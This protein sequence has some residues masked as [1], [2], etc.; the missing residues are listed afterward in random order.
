M[1]GIFVLA[2]FM[3]SAIQTQKL[4]TE[5]EKYF[6]FWLGKW[7]VSWDE[8]NGVTG[9]GTNHI[10]R[11]LDG[12]VI[13]ENFEILEGQSKGFK[14]TS[15]SVYN[16]NQ[17]KWKQAWADSQGGY[18]DFTGSVDGEKRMFQSAVINKPDGKRFTQRMVF[19]NIQTN[20]L[21]WDW[22]SSFDGGE[23]WELKW[24]I[25]YKREE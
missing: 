19:Y 23:T 25:N 7:K 18:Y 14:G 4:P 16:P 5:P 6:D 1:K 12:K 9:R 15:L 21:T 17:Q 24:R 2:L 22:E 8:G 11:I 20:E 3:V 13:Q 10:V